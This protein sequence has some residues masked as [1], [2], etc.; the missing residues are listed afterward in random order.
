[1]NSKELGENYNKIA[2]WWTDAQMKKPEFGMEY[3]RKAIRYAKKKSNVLDIGCGG[4]G[5]VIEEAL[6]HDFIVTGIDVSLKK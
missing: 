4:T 5:R 1:M 6:K 3:I 2:E